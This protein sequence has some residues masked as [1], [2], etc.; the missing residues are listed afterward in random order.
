MNETSSPVKKRPEQS[1]PLRRTVRATRPEATARVIER[2][3]GRDEKVN[4]LFFASRLGGGG[5]EMH[6]LRVMNHLDRSKFR[7]SLAVTRPTGPLMS[8]LAGDIKTHVLDTGSR[9]STTVRMMRAI[10]PLRRLVN[11]ER[12]DVVCSMMELA[13][14]VNLLASSGATHRPQIVLGVQTPPSIALRQGRQPVS[15]LALAL[16]PRLYTRADGIIALSRGVADDVASLAPRAADRITTIYN[17]G[18]ESSVIEKAREPLADDERPGAHPVIVACGRLK[19]L[20]GFNHLIDALAIVRKSVAAELWIIGEGEERAK[21]EKQIARLGLNDCVRLMGFKL[22]PYKY[23]AA[24]DVFVLS[25]LYEG[26]GNVIVEAMA[27]STPVV[28]ADCPYGPREIIEDGETGLLVPPADAGAM[29]KAI[30]RVLTDRELKE[31]LVRGA[32]ARA[33]DFSAETIAAAY[34]DA[35]LDLVNDG[36]CK[37]PGGGGD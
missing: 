12:P 7:V 10:A 11:R 13:N 23:M 16:I 8:A 26:F 37:S 25:S 18:F 15:R 4:V 31:R 32:R 3:G 2:E 21:L 36:A 17:A 19:A 34:G 6:L 1:Y 30:L 5:A 29:A 24:A 27:C 35:L 9:D 14:L 33:V 22:N 20:K 28:A